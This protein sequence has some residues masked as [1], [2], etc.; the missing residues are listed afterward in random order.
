MQSTKVIAV[1]VIAGGAGYLLLRRRPDGT[2]ALDTLTGNVGDLFAP[3]LQ[4]A[5]GTVQERGPGNT[6]GV[7]SQ[8]MSKG[9]A[10]IGAIGAGSALVGGLLGTSGA[11]AAAG[12]AGAAAATGGGGAAAAATAGGIGLGATVA[13]TGGI[14]GGVLLTWA[15]WKKGL[16]RGGEEALHVNEDRDT[17]TGQFG[18]R[19][20]GDGK[21]GPSWTDS[22]NGK[23]AALLSEVTG[24]PNGSHYWTALAQADKRDT[25]V[26]A[27]RAIQALLET[28]GIHIQAP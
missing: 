10:V 16:F 12:A 24:E 9:T 27:T 19:W 8:P 20:Q 26:A 5:A 22:G 23:L 4:A 28:R 13:I 21:G 3:R 17:F 6:G 1:V 2:S 7:P 11:T 14:A 18:P 25:F 15:I